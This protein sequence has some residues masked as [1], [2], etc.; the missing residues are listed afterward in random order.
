MPVQIDGE[1]DIVV[2]LALR[3]G[4]IDSA[5]AKEAGGGGEA[6][7]IAAAADAGTAGEGREGT[8]F[9]LR[10]DR[11]RT[12][13]AA[14]DD[15]DDPADRFAPVQ[16]ALR[17]AQD[18]DPLDVGG[19]VIRS[20][21]RLYAPWSTSLPRL[22]DAS[23]GRFPGLRIVGV[24]SGL[25]RTP[26]SSGS[27][28]M[29]ERLPPKVARTAPASGRIGEP[30]RIPFQPLGRGTVLKGK[31][32]L[33]MCC[34]LIQVKHRSAPSYPRHPAAVET[35]LRGRAGTRSPRDAIISNQRRRSS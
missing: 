29:S 3:A 35:P 13:S 22:C 1:V 11:D 21:R 34:A 7:G 4:D 6:A 8:A 31:L 2:L 23:D 9:G 10:A 18:L 19:Y 33:W 30:H 25:P 20:P 24:R 32:N 15:V 27:E 14:G 12:V 17:P 5:G 26:G 28:Q 16:G